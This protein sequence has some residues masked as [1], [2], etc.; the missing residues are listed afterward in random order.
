M[1][2]LIVCISCV[3]PSVLRGGYGPVGTSN[4]CC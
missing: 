2:V 4:D 3:R 1:V